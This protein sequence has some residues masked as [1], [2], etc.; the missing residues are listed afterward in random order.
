[1]HALQYSAVNFN[2]PKSKATCPGM[3]MEEQSRVTAQEAEAEQK[4]RQAATALRRVAR[5]AAQ[6]E[7]K[8]RTRV[9]GLVG[10][11]AR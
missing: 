10:V 4:S 7:A 1:M 9:A 11:R 8:A 2:Q 5:R 6:A 3:E